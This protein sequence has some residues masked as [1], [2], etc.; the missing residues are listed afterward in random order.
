MNLC[1]RKQLLAMS[2]SR[3]FA[4]RKKE[5]TVW[6]WFAHDEVQAKSTCLALTKERTRIR[7]RTKIMLP[8]R[9][10]ER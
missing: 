5:S 9:E 3:M 7:T 2:L 6:Q 1:A 10:R 4:G 8:E